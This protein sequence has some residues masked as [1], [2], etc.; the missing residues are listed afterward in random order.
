VTRDLAD[1]GNPATPDDDV[2][3]GVVLLRDS[4]DQ[5]RARLVSTQQLVPLPP[6]FSI[7]TYTRGG[8]HVAAGLELTV[9]GP[10]V[11]SYKLADVA[12]VGG[13]EATPSFVPV[14]DVNSHLALMPLSFDVA[15]LDD[16]DRYDVAA[17]IALPNGPRL[18]VNL[19]REING[20]ELASVSDLLPGGRQATS[21]FVR[22]LDIDGKPP[23]EML[24]LT[25]EGAD[26]FCLPSTAPGAAQCT[27]ATP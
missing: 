17:A 25:N 8:K 6:V 20:E 13:G 2:D 1:D 16:D 21:V 23:G 15:D 10:R 24:V 3:E 19:G 18:Q 11:V 5:P 4:D 12:A 7:A 26:V 22:F 27:P 14:D 9:Q